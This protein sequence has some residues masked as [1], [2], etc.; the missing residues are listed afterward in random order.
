M[1]VI[2]D[3]EL[4]LLVSRTNK[5]VLLSK[6]DTGNRSG[7][8]GEDFDITIG[9]LTIKIGYYLPLYF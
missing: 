4:S 7:V 1:L 8:V 9:V 2:P 6:S 5:A 3:F